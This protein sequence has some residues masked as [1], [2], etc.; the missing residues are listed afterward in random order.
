MHDN[1]KGCGNRG[2]GRNTRRGGFRIT[3]DAQSVDR[4]QRPARIEPLDDALFD[5]CSRH[6]RTARAFWLMVVAMVFVALSV[7]AILLLG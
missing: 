6:S 4:P 7:C 2:I 1:R 5:R 3:R